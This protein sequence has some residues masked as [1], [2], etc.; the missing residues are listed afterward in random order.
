MIYGRNVFDQA[1]RNGIRTYNN[2]KKIV[3]GQ[4]GDDTTESLL[5]YPCFKG[6]CKLIQC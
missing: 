2:L 4:R 6:I 3:T 1:V 5:D